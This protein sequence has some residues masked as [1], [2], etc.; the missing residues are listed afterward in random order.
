MATQEQEALKP[1]QAVK[2]N[3]RFSKEIIEE[4]DKLATL[5]VK[6]TPHKGEKISDTIRL[7]RKVDKNQRWTDY[8]GRNL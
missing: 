1:K 4:T 7:D 2:R 6:H 8:N 5:R 3:R